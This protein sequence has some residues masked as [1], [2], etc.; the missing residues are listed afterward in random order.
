V[1]LILAIN[2]GNSHS[3]TLARLARELQ[4]CELIG[5]DSCAVAIAAIN[6]RVPDLVL[7][8]D[9]PA[10]GEADLLARLRAVPGGVLTVKLPPVSS[11][12]PPALAKE[13]RTILAGEAAT[14]AAPAPSAAPAPKVA[15]LSPHLV[16]AANAMIEWVHLRQA[17][18]A[19]EHRL[20]A[21]EPLP[22]S[23]HTR[24][25]EPHEPSE[26]YEPHEPNEPQEPY[27]P[28]LLAS[29]E[30]VTGT[31][32]P[33]VAIV[34]ALAGAA[35]AGIWLWPNIRGGT[36]NAVAQIGTP[37]D[38][39]PAQDAA[40]AAPPPAAETP[41]PAPS[42]A[43]PV[44]GKPGAAPADAADVVA[45]FVAVSAPFD[46]SI[47]NANEAVAIDDRG[48]GTLP[49]GKYRLRFRNPEVGYDETRTVVIRPTETTTVNLVPQ[50][51]LRV[52][53]NETA[54]VLVDGE[55][56]G[57]TPFDGRISYGAHTI[58]VRSAG[59]ER[60]FQIDATMKP[61]ELEVD[62]SKP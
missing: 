14:P 23:A 53:A 29:A 60:Q 11:A 9:K 56:T 40:S 1:A 35:G 19:D 17:Q 48:R 45:G 20:L 18:W 21:P 50:T 36:S 51:S 4:G 28:D 52:T 34:A 6:K 10:R 47:S 61:V 49:S 3:P 22:V 44:V 57:E 2:P 12:D 13:I 7:L 5:A 31:W 15:A 43:E 54:Q 37:Q 16:A 39:A 58:T 32:L 55:G 24:T 59:G 46:I 38:A 8:P 26:P 33:R 25:D 42:A 27:E 62:F 30:P 41:T